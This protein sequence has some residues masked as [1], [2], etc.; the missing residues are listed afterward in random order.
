MVADGDESMASS[1]GGC[2][3][4]AVALDLRAQKRSPSMSVGDAA[5]GEINVRLGRSSASRSL[6]GDAGV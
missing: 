5:R 2:L 6:C 3:F 1:D 4:T